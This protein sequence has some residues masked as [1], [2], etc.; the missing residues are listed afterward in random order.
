MQTRR[1]SLVEA[2]INIGVGFWI[3]VWIN[4][5]ILPLFGF[6]ISLSQ[7]IQ[8]ALLFTVVSIIRSYF[9]RRAF[10]WISVRY[11]F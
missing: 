7:N 3:S 5:V 6:A 4:S 8:M 1:G 10:N 2:I 11:K 9:L